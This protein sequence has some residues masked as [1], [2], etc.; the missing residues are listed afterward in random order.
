MGRLKR[1]EAR[2][3]LRDELERVGYEVV[4]A[5][6]IEEGARPGS[7]QLDWWHHNTPANERSETLR[8][9]AY[10]RIASDQPLYA[11][12]LL[13]DKKRLWLDRSVMSRCER[14]GY[15]A[16]E[17]ELHPRFILTERGREWLRTGEPKI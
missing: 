4:S 15:I 6:Q 10:L 14:D 5:F 8:S 3:I 12:G 1:A 16:F 13:L 7:D 2:E 11:G 17:G 9:Q